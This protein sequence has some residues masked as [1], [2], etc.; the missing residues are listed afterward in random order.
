MTLGIIAGGGPLPGQVALAAR[1][2]GRGVFVVALEG[3]AEVGVIGAFPHEVVRLG[4]VGAAVASAHDDIANARVHF[5]DGC[6]ATITASRI[7]L[8]TERKMRIFSEAGYLTVD[9]AAKT[10]TLIGRDRGMALPGFEEFGLETASW[11]D[12]DALAAEHAAFH[13]A[14]LDGG[15]V[16]VD[17]AAGRRALEAA[18]KVSASIAASRARAVRSGLIR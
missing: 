10:L 8:K 7:S 17:A 18:I 15:A 11:Q 12:H 5:A 14:C 1:A 3:Y 16:L 6:V 4:A 9:F 2:A 13:A